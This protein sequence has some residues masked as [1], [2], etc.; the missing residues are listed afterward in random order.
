MVRSGVGAAEERSRSQS[1]SAVGARSESE[2]RRSVRCVRGRAAAW[3]RSG[4]GAAMVR[5]RVAAA[6]VSGI[7]A[8]SVEDSWRSMYGS[9]P[10]AAMCNAP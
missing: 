3:S 9:A 6:M 2:L 4:V 8:E 5:T 7:V 1:R 10:S